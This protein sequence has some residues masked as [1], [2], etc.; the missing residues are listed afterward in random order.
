MDGL[1][2]LVLIGWLISQM[3]KKKKTPKPKRTLNAS[4]ENAAQRK[5]ERIAQ[6][7]AELEKRRAQPLRERQP[8]EQMVNSEGESATAYMPMEEAFRGSM[9]VN[10]TEGECICDPELE[11][12]REKEPS[13]TSVYAGEIGKDPLVDFS[14]RGVLQGF[15]MSEILTR[16]A[17][18]A[19]R[20]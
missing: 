2:V 11:H 12:E 20:H 17:Q 7:Q 9:Q 5:A 8:V 16:P 19:R 4:K 10:S 13:P 15:V 6:M 3:S 14:A 1:L 18:R